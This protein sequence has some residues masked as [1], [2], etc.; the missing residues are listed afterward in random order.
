MIF[1]ALGHGDIIAAHNI[2]WQICHDSCQFFHLPDISE[3]L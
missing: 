3:L 2:G 1:D